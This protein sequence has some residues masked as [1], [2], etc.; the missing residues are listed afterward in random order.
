MIMD[1]APIAMLA[2]GAFVM[3]MPI[4]TVVFL[5]TGKWQRLVTDILYAIMS[6]RLPFGLQSLMIINILEHMS[7]VLTMTVKIPIS[8]QV[9][10]AL[11][12]ES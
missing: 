11:N 3:G 10:S 9:R 2:L 12:A 1:V 8:M 4:V 5:R 7:S 6:A